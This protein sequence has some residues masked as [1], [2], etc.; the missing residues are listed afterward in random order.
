MTSHVWAPF[1]GWVEL[2]HPILFNGVRFLE[3]CGQL[4]REGTHSWGR[5]GV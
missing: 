2:G 1:G 5:V 3:F 4:S